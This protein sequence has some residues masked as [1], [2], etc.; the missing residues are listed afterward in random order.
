MRMIRLNSEYL[1]RVLDG[2][3]PLSQREFHPA[4]LVLGSFDGLHRGHQELVEALRAAKDRRGLKASILFTFRSHPRLTLGGMD[5]PFLLTT[6]REKL[7]LLEQLGVDVLVAVDFNPELAKVDY[8]RFVG[9]FLVGWLGMT[10]MVAGRDVHVGAG[11]RGDA[12]ALAALGAELGYTLEV[13]PAATWQGRVISSSAIRNAL[14]AGDC[15][16][17]TAMLGRPYAMWGEV[18]PGEGR[19]RTIGYPTANVQPVNP[20]KL[21]PSPGVYACRVQVPGDVVA[22]GGNGALDLVEE[23]LPELD[24]QGDMVAPGLGRWRRYGG[25]LNF[26]HVP[27][28]HAGG[29]AQPRIE[30]HLLDFAGDLRGRTIKVE[31]LQRLRDERRFAGV[32]ELLAQLRLDEQAARRVTAALGRTA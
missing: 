19:G 11:R 29:L 5:G 30:V 25:M 10:H 13:L 15:A 7:S 1:G 23:P 8:R 32:E 17:A 3:T 22:E 20:R 9:Q 31:W 26:G 18:C 4:G 27:T 12:A 14:A 21:L 24:R 28:F 16:A 2:E 6:W